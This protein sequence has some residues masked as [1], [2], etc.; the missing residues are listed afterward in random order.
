[1][2]RSRRW[3]DKSNIFRTKW[4]VNNIPTIVRFER[5]DGQVKE[6]GRLVE[7]EILDEKKLGEFIGQ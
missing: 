4:N 5:A 7:A 2:S 6:T 3:K 1:M